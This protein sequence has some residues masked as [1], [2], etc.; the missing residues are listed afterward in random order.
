MVNSK[1]TSVLLLCL[2]LL[3]S[4]MTWAQKKPQPKPN[5]IPVQGYATYSVGEDEAIYLSEVRDKCILRAKVNAIKA[6]FGERISVKEEALNDHYFQQVLAESRADWLRDVGKPKVSASYEDGLLTFTAEVK[7][8]IREIKVSKID[9][10]Y[11]VL[12]N[13][14][15]ETTV[16]NDGER[17]LLNFKSPIDGYVAVYLL[18]D[19]NDSATRLLPYDGNEE[20]YSVKRNKDYVFF[21]KSVDRDATEYSLRTDLEIERDRLAIIFSKNPVPPCQSV[22]NNKSSLDNVSLGAFEA[23]LSKSRNM[24]AGMVVLYETITILN[25]KKQQ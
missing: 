4:G 23:W 14:G 8:V 19:I 12:T 18:D 1:W 9:V 7:G 10:Q 21:D 5:E 2:C 13:D 17:L 22:R 3:Q 20:G 15:R 11:K 24:D 6:K 25:N 16:L